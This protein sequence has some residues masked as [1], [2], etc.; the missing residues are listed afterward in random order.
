M[1]KAGSFQ[2]LKVLLNMDVDYFPVKCSRRRLMGETLFFKTLPVHDQAGTAAFLGGNIMKT[3][4]QNEKKDFPNKFSVIGEIPF[5][6]GIFS[7]I[8]GVIRKV[9]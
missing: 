4:R 6:N 1:Q 5:K 7:Y 2:Q 9:V 8:P 3:L